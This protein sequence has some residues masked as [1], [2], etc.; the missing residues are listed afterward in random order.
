MLEAFAGRPG[1]PPAVLDYYR[2][3]VP[4]VYTVGPL[5]LVARLRGLAMWAVGLFRPAPREP[6]S[7]AELTTWA[8]KST[9]LACENL[10]LAFRAR[11]WDTCPMEGMDSARVRRLL[12]LPRGATVVMVVAAGRR[13]PKGV[14]GPRVRFDRALFVREH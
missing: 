9:A 7:R 11:G 1:V 6:A 2:R 4:F 8:V 13:S 3:L 5:G 10:M 14:Y 12:G